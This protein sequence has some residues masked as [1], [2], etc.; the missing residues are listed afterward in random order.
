MK[1]FWTLLCVM[2][3][4]VCFCFAGCKKEGEANATV[5][6]A[7]DTRI[8]IRIDKTIGDAVLMDAMEE[9]EEKDKLSFTVSEGMITSLNGVENAA[10][11]SACWMLYTSDG[12]MANSAWGTLEYE[13]QTLGS[14][15]V[16]AEDLIVS[17][18]ELYIWLY[19]TF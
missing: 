11:Y 10:D 16:G 12:E 14:A 19:Q 4:S 13:G 3:I 6:S 8:V 1:K 7:T 2:L 15:M 18:G 5:L 9:L 17:E